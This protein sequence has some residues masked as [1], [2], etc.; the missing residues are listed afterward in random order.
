MLF[1]LISFIAAASPKNIQ[2]LR[3][4]G[5]IEKHQRSQREYELF[6]IRKQI[7]KVYLTKAEAEADLAILQL[8]LLKINSNFE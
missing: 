5:N 1:C 7:E 3:E 2:D 4:N 8:K 6:E